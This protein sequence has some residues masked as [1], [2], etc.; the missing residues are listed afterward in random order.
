MYLCAFIFFKLK[1]YCF[2]R[3][4][5]IL[6]HYQKCILS[7]VFYCV[8]EV[9][10]HFNCFLSFFKPIQIFATDYDEDDT[11]IM[12]DAEN[13]FAHTQFCGFE[14][15]KKWFDLKEKQQQKFDEKD[16]KN[17]KNA[18]KLYPIHVMISI[19]R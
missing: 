3:L 2:N 15:F 6:S 14:K 7:K 4:N 10:F 16:E 19:L 18:F 1:I 12:M 8:E 11:E 13:P 5:I 9:F 17:Y